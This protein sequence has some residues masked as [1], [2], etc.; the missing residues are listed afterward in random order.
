MA[1]WSRWIPPGNFDYIPV[2]ENLQQVCPKRK[3]VV[4]KVLC[5]TMWCFKQGKNK[6]MVIILR[7]LPVVNPF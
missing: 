1:V 6:G 3:V 5:C 4:F 2:P 7:R